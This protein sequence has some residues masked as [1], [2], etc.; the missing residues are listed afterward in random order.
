MILKCLGS[1]SRG[2]CY[3]LE[4]ADETLIVEAGIPMRDIKRVSAGNSAKW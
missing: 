4:A 3:I 2:N 1:S